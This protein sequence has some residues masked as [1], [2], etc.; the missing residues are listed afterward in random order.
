MAWVKAAGGGSANLNS[1]I[2]M[3]PVISQEHQNCLLAYLRQT[4]RETM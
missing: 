2:E 3:E 1:Q 4:H